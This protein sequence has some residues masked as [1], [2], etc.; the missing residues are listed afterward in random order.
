M[1]CWED[2]FDETS[3][4]SKTCVYD[5]ANLG[6]SDPAATPRT[7]QDMVDDLHRLLKNAN[8]P[9]PFIMVGHSMGGF[10][11]LIFAHDYPGDVD[12]LILVDPSHPDQYERWLAILPAELPTQSESLKLC[13]QTL[14][15][16]S[17]PASTNDPNNPEGWDWPQSAEEVRSIKDLGD[18][19]LTVITAGIN[20]WPCYRPLADQ[21]MKTW[22]ANH[23]DYLKLSTN[24]KQI[25][26]GYSNHMVMKSEPELILS[27]MREM[28]DVV[29]K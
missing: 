29:R 18:L 21:E 24:S 28:L 22:Q 15:T 6:L 1:A 3:K 10:N 13:R 23:Q 20:S 27:A 19:P 5:R 26:A 7:S 4:Y 11:A 16:S 12:G 25:L 9:A 14:K 17:A 2:I 8:V